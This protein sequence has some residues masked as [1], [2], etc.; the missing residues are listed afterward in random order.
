MQGLVAC[1]LITQHFLLHPHGCG[2]I[3][4]QCDPHS[5]FE[6]TIFFVSIYL[7]AL[8][9]GAAE[10]ALATFGADQFDEEDPEESKSKT[11]F[12]S[13]FYVALNMGSLIG[14]TILVYIE[15]MGYWVVGFWI[16]TGCAVAAVILLFSGTLRYRHFRP[17]G[18]PISRFC[19]VIV[20][21]FRKMNV[22][23]PQDGE[24]LFEVQG[25]DGETNGARRLLHTNGFK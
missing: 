17:S 6:T 18:N 20:A 19:Q 21:A 4:Q 5:G 14:E 13:Y 12:F 7:V 8:G 11:S 1:S 16:S 15:N 25:K 24:G 22:E 9:N 2:T 23:V 10:P 3:E